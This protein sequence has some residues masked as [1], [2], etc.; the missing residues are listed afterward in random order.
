MLWLAHS[1][2]NAANASIFA[3][4][5]LTASG[6]SKTAQAVDYLLGLGVYGTLKILG[7]LFIVYMIF[8][9]L[10]V[11]VAVP[12]GIAYPWVDSDTK[13]MFANWRFGKLFAQGNIKNWLAIGSEK[14]RRNDILV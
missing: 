6:R 2:F 11:K 9:T 14:V 1:G 5:D 3:H 7:P 4:S 13:K 8:A 10:T 12:D